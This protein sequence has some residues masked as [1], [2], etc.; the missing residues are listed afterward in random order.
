MTKRP[1]PLKDP[2]QYGWIFAAYWLPCVV[3]NVIAELPQVLPT[4]CY[5]LEMRLRKCTASGAK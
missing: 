4:G 2:R 3:S 1:L 5:F